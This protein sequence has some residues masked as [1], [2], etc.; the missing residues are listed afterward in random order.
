MRSST[1]NFKS[2]LSF[3]V[4][5]S[6]LTGRA[7]SSETAE[8]SDW[9]D[10]LTKKSG[11]EYEIEERLFVSPHLR[12][13]TL[14]I[15]AGELNIL[16]SEDDFFH[17]RCS[18][19]NNFLS[20]LRFSLDS[21]ELKLEDTNDVSK[22]EDQG[23]FGLINSIIS[24]HG[25][26][27]GIGSIST[28][29]CSVKINDGRGNIVNRKAVG[30]MMTSNSFAKIHGYLP[31]NDI[32]RLL[33]GEGSTCLSFQCE[34]IQLK[35]VTMGPN[36]RIWHGSIVAGQIEQDEKKY[37]PGTDFRNGI[38]NGIGLEGQNS[39][40]QETVQKQEPKLTEI[41]LQ[42]PDSLQGR[43]SLQ[44]N[45]RGD[46][47][48]NVGYLSFET[49]QGRFGRK[50][51]FNAE[52][53]TS[54]YLTL[55]GME[56]SRLTYKGQTLR[57]LCLNSSDH[58]STT[59]IAP[60]NILAKYNRE[61]LH[62]A[63]L[64]SHITLSNHATASVQDW[65]NKLIINANDHAKITCTPVY[66]MEAVKINASNHVTVNMVASI[67]RAQIVAR[68]HSKV[69]VSKVTK[70]LDENAQ[71]YAKINIGEKP[72]SNFVF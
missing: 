67:E 21:T 33:G 30:M 8:I 27:V 23:D 16:P 50:S 41:F 51:T 32:A 37:G 62:Q 45:G 68:D 26:N 28:N 57:S 25:I 3:I 6:L 14:T 63:D 60:N 65:F 72:Q 54:S 1:K 17:I 13:M 47:K 31:Q 9:P 4:K 20:N 44:L 11:C 36:G 53:T 70:T 15:N 2:M 64:V 40:S 61:E 39:Q 34:G 38:P 52:S 42:I 69:N 10:Y 19:E 5:M 71:G 59:I 7:F 18:G 66:P 58:S 43:L 22:A 56:H 48:V 35:N 12:Q 55:T 29:V 46:S 24:Q 49:L